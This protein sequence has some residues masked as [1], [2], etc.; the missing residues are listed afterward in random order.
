MNEE[1]YFAT[2]NEFTEKTPAKKM[3]IDAFKEITP[4]KNNWIAFVISFVLGV[5][6]AAIIGINENTVKILLAIVGVLLNVLLYIFGY[7]FTIYAILLAFL[8]DKYIK[9]LAKLKTDGVSSL[10]ISTKYYESVLFL[11]F[12]G[13]CIT[14]VILL[15]LNCIVN[16]WVLTSNYII[17]NSL[18][19]LVLIIYFTYIFRIIYELKSAIYNTIVLFRE[20]IAY[21]LLIIFKKEREG[22]HIDNDNK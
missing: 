11:Y 15:F 5:F 20:S 13:L 10:M 22:E 4:D 17:N 1:K 19:V 18:A 6:F 16:E 21:K 14:G 2:I 8:S 7:L 12:I 9:E 3:I